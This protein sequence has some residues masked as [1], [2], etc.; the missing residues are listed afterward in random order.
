ML[1]HDPAN[2]AGKWFSRNKR[3]EGSI[4]AGLNR[5]FY[6]SRRREKKRIDGMER[7]SCA[8]II[9]V[10]AAP[11][12]ISGRVRFPRADHANS[13]RAG[14]FAEWKRA[15]PVESAWLFCAVH[16]PAMAKSGLNGSCTRSASL[17]VHFSEYINTRCASQNRV[18]CF[19][20]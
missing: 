6:Q 7:D 13:N 12:R 17:D 20:Y 11:V 2:S 14:N 5:R 19:K 16:P 10:V 3:N 8:G 15:S 1:R 9:V 4:L 18:E